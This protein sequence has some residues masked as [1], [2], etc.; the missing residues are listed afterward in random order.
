M[1]SRIYD[2][3]RKCPLLLDLLKFNLGRYASDYPQVRNEI[4]DPGPPLIATIH[5]LFREWEAKR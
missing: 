2:S 1:S 4:A 5:L 3:E